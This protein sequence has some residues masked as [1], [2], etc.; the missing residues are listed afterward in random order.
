MVLQEL[1]VH[2]ELVV[3][4]VLQVHQEQAVLQEL[5]VR[6]VHQELVVQMVLQVRQ[7]LQVVMEHQVRQVLQVVMEH[8]VHQEQVEPREKVL[9]GRVISSLVNS[10]QEIQLFIIMVVHILQLQIIKVNIL[11][12]VR[13]GI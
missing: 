11:M 10:T 6:T 1:T 12:Q 7:V 2:Q 9:I 13:I 8:Q 4:T 5:V 3:Q